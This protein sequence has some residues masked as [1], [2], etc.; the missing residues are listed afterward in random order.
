[1]PLLLREMRS[2]GRARIA[3]WEGGGLWFIE[4]AR[5]LSEVPFHAHHAIQITFLL[6]GTMTIATPDTAFPGPVVAV[7][8]DAEHSL[9]L[10]GSAALLFIDPESSFGRAAK[11]D[12][13]RGQDAV[14][15]AYDRVAST[16][17]ELR[18][19]WRDL[20]PIADLRS[21]G[22]DLAARLL[23]V[24]RAAPTDAR[25]AAIIGSL[26]DRLD[27]PL[28]LSDVA[29]SIHLSPSR[30][31]HLFVE[32]TGLPFKSYVLWRRMMRAVELFSTGVSLTEAAHAAGF[33][34]SAHFSRTCRR[35]FGLPASAVEYV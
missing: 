5:D 23:G 17:E 27:G 24:T 28:S 35:T 8:A 4:A 7:D 25:V 22:Q 1:M 34:D 26:A 16:A 32:Q 31:R 15:I 18:A 12:L 6:D 33:S 10:S 30:L 20:R 11:A 13:L 14:V 9:A 19:A 2:V 3:V 29:R 21:L